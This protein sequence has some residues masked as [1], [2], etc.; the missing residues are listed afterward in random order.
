MPI[1]TQCSNCQKTM[2]AP[3]DWAGRVIDCPGC[4]SQV[5]IPGGLPNSPAPPPLPASAAMNETEIDRIPE[6]EKPVE[7][8]AD[9]PDLTAADVK[10]IVQDA[11]AE[12]CASKPQVVVR[13][14]E[15]T[16]DNMVRLV[17]GFWLATIVA[18]IIIGI[19]I[20]L[21]AI[22]LSALGR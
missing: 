16:F 6:T 2:R 13:A 8:T 17:L 14:I 22:V 15:L 10:Q 21:A 5:V 1:R 9:L 12:I 19:V 20:G 3:D 4:G 11:V 7:W 18:A